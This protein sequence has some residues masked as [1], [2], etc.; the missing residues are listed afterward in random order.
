MIAIDASVLADAL[1]D[2]GPVG[3]A[4][5]EALKS[6]P[7][8]AAPPH[9]MIEVASVIR[10]KALGRKVGLARA[11]DAI[12]ALSTLVID[13]VGLDNL[14]RRVWQL[15]GNLSAYDA[16][17]IAT[18]EMLDCPLMTGDARLA[19]ANGVRCEIRV[20]APA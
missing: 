2:D 11:N 16:A 3:T 20:I 7:H 14:I 4:A 1:L 5:R 13:Q 12:E 9:L 18:A 10:G 15:R 6:D 8:W 19:K 17:Y